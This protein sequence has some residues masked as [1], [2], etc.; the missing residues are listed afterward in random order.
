MAALGR[1]STAMDAVQGHDLSGKVICVTGGNGG[2]GFE[3]CKALASA[4]AHVIMCSRSVEAGET[5]AQEILATGVKV[6]KMTTF[7]GE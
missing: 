6:R 7:V 3:S 2:L 4:G 1:S 5:A